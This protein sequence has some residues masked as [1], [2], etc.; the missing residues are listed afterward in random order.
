MP[1]LQQPEIRFS[2]PK[3]RSCIVI[4]GLMPN[5]SATFYQQIT[6]CVTN[7]EGSIE[8]VPDF[9]ERSMAYGETWQAI[10]NGPAG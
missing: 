3:W 1:G 2:L 8:A 4:E 10:L 9:V 5:H 6:I 7:L